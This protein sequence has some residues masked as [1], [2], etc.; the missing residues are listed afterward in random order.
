MKKQKKQNTAYVK[1]KIDTKL[2]S[3]QVSKLIDDAV[4]KDMHG[5]LALAVEADDGLVLNKRWKLSAVDKNDYFVV[6]LYSG[7]KV[8]EHIALFSNAVQIIWYLSKPIRKP[9]LMDR[10]IYELDQ[11]YYRCL[12]DIRY[13][14]SKVTKNPELRDLFSI[15]LGQSKYRLQDIKNEISKIY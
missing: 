1:E 4:P 11:E 12:E 5:M 15:R 8:Y 6:D 3:K 9:F 2:L 13:Y 14:N 10:V 7:E